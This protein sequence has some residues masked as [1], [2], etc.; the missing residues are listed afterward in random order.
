MLF[1]NTATSRACP[2]NATS[3]DPSPGPKPD[4]RKRREV[5]NTAAQVIVVWL[6][7]LA[8][9]WELQPDKTE[10]HMSFPD[11]KVKSRVFLLALFVCYFFG[12]G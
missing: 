4:C 9:H 2:E 3:S 5:V 12:M 7:E 6:L 11:A 8:S 1:N 10:I